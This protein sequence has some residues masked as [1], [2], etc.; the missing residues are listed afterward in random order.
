MKRDVLVIWGNNTSNAV[1]GEPEP[2]TSSLRDVVMMHCMLNL[3]THHPLNWL[4]L[5]ET[6]WNVYKCHFTIDSNG[7]WE[8]EAARLSPLQLNGRLETKARPWDE[9]LGKW[10]KG[11]AWLAVRN[12][13]L[14][15]SHRSWWLLKNACFEKGFK[16]HLLPQSTV[17]TIVKRALT[18]R[19]VNTWVH[20]CLIS[21]GKSKNNL[22]EGVRVLP[23]D[24]Q[25]SVENVNGVCQHRTHCHDARVLL[26]GC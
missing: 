18:E 21:F 11:G 16:S 22:P 20:I 8:E 25:L 15:R 13:Y 19:L 9:H 3:R 12:R 17:N 24:V 7:C 14:K 10:R 6:D 5:N 4:E 23:L 1:S 2:V 26:C